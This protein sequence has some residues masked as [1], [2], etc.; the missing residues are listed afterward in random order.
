MTEPSY[1]NTTRTSYDT[2]AVTYAELFRNAL[3]GLPLERG[4]LTAFAELVQAAGGGPVADLGC[5]PGMG[6]AFLHSLGLDVSGT[7]LSPT[8]IELARKEYPDIRFDEGSMTELDLPDGGLAGAVSWYSII[9]TPPERLPVVF[10]EFDRVLAPGGYLLLAFQ[11]SREGASHAA[12]PF[13][14]KVT[15]AYRWPIDG[16]AELAREAGFVE[17]ARLLREREETERFEAGHLLV[18]KPANPE[19]A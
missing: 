14:H 16:V 13:D 15:L 8:M 12:E 6:T 7:D 18:R 4:L 3:D 1:L 19:K 5:G 2:V 10:A 9:H 17:V 11:A